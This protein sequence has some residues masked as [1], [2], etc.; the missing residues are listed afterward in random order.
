ML[1]RSC[2]SCIISTSVEKLMKMEVN[3]EENIMVKNI[4]RFWNEQSRN[5]GAGAFAVAMTLLMI[6]MR[7]VGYFS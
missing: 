7:Y 3:K 2:F 1:F 4:N 5:I 6:T